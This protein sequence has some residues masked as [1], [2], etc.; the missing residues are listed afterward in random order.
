VPATGDRITKRKDGL[1]QGMYI[2]QTLDGPKRK[3][4]YGRKYGD[5]KRKLAEAMGDGPEV[6]TST[7]RTNPWRSIWSAG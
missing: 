3:Y 5:V 4:I 2:A 7:M 1:F 6:S